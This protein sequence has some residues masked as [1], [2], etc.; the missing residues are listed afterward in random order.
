MT[1]EQL[2]DTLPEYAKDLRLNVS[3]VFRQTELTE[4]QTWGAVVAAAITARNQRLTGVLIAE[5]AAHLTPEALRAAKAA[6]AVMGMNNVYYRFTHMVPGD[7][8]PTIPARLRMNVIRNHGV[9]AVDFE[10]WCIVASA[11]NNCSAC[12]T[13]HERVIRDKGMTEEAVLAA[14]RIAAVV[15]SLAPVIE[16]AEVS[17]AA[18]AGV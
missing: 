5:A 10:L 2:L 9:D 17:E 13:S 1:L 7:R 16:A 18:P 4:Q 3:S 8:Y 12:V 15:H 11:V 14:V 6:A